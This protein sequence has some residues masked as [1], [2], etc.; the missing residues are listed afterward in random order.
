M[1][2]SPQCGDGPFIVASVSSRSCAMG[3]LLSRYG[4]LMY[5]KDYINVRRPLTYWREL[6]HEWVFLVHRVYR[7]SNRKA[8]VYAEKERA[9]TG[10]LAAAATRNGWVALEE[11]RSQKI[12][13]YIENEEYSGR[14]DLMLWRDRKHHIIEAKHVRHPI[15]ARSISRID[16]AHSRAL[17]DSGRSMSSGYK[18]EKMVAITYIV[19]VVKPKN[20]EV[21]TKEEISKKLSEVVEDV[22]KKH[23]PTFMAYAFPGVVELQ[24]SPNLGLGVIVIGQVT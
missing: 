6:L 4:L 22:R 23:S 1:A 5:L 7:V 16:R 15:G 12:Y 17:A 10:L 18:S 11:C 20:F 8:A 3:T 24:G 19:P 9:N 2:A 21:M 13:R 14:C